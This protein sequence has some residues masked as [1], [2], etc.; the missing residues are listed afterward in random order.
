[1]Q[2]LVA[3]EISRV[4]IVTCLCHRVGGTRRVLP[5]PQVLRAEL[6]EYLT[7]LDCVAQIDR[8]LEHL[9]ADPKTQPRLGAR[10][11]FSGI[12]I[13]AASGLPRNDQGPHRAHRIGHAVGPR[14]RNE[15]GDAGHGKEQHVAHGNHRRKHK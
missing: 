1:V 13:D 6:G 3:L 8:T 10:P 4:L 11:E 7:G 2:I 9:A 14:A 15:R 12:F 5:Q